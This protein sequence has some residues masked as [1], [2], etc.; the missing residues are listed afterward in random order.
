MIPASVPRTIQLNAKLESCVAL[1]EALLRMGVL[2]E[3]DWTGGLTE[4]LQQGFQR[5]VHEETLCA[6]LQCLSPTLHYSEDAATFSIDRGF[7]HQLPGFEE[8]DTE[9]TEGEIGVFAITVNGCFSLA[10]EPVFEALARLASPELAW[11]VYAALVGALRVTIGCGAADWA[12]DQV[13][14]WC[15]WHDE[16][17]E[18][19]D[20]ATWRT[21]LPYQELI[22]QPLDRSALSAL[23]EREKHSND[24]LLWQIATRSLRLLGL[25]DR[26]PAWAN[27]M[28]AWAPEGDEWPTGPVAGALVHWDDDNDPIARVWDD[29]CELNSQTYGWDHTAWAHVWKPG[30]RRWS[31]H[32]AVVALRWTLE[33]VGVADLLLSHLIALKHR[34]RKQP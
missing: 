26:A 32:R 4:S 31:V 9:E 7:L 3:S 34:E 22:E 12:Q 10:F 15:E 24:P 29:Y 16:E 30:H 19:H 18:V 6:N 8:T 13:S 23:Q 25:M 17:G 5:W 27:H 28:F 2:K 14:Q 11:S 33:V 20:P 21:L 1:A